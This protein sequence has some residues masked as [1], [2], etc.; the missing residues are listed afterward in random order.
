MRGWG[1]RGRV[2]QVLQGQVLGG[3]LRNPS[4][5]ELLL[6]GCQ[7]TQT[8]QD[9]IQ[10]DRS[11]EQA[12]PGRPC[13]TTLCPANKDLTKACSASQLSFSFPSRPKSWTQIGYLLTLARQTDS[14]KA[15]FFLIGS[16]YSKKRMSWCAEDNAHNNCLCLLAIVSLSDI[17]NPRPSQPQTRESEGRGL[18]AWGGEKT[19]QSEKSE[20][21]GRNWEEGVRSWKVYKKLCVHERGRKKKRERNGGRII[22]RC[23][24][25]KSSF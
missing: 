19:Q 9:Q 12:G 8:I 5:V 20:N 14:C 7:G 21:K 10:A 18:R 4:W 24:L 11:R 1:I 3:P 17:H 16:K 22:L 13:S 6:L 2:S 23:I 25:N 15:D